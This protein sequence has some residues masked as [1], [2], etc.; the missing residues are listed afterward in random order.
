MKTVMI[1]AGGVAV[2]L[3]GGCLDTAPRP[4]AIELCDSAGCRVVPAGTALYDPATAVPDPDPQGILPGLVAEAER[5]PRAAADLAMRFMRGDGIRQDSYQAVRWMRDAAERGNLRAQ[6]ALGR[7]YLTGLEE[8]GPDY[9]EAAKWLSIAAAQGD[10]E[11]AELVE[12]AEAERAEE[13]AFQEEIRRTREFVTRTYWFETAYFG[14][15]DYFG[16]TGTVVYN[17][18]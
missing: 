8:A 2:G 14:G 13:Q 6:G 18:Y 4:E 5:D 7:L 3:L 1:V 16:P 9:N 10:R 17:Y 15:Y 12:L 11:A